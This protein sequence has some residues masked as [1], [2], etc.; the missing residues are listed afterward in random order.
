MISPYYS[1]PVEDYESSTEIHEDC[2]VHLLPQNDIDKWI[3]Y[4]DPLWFAKEPQS[5]LKERFSKLARQWGDETGHLSSPNQKMLHP[6]Y[7]AI[8]GM[9]QEHRDE[10]IDLLLQDLK[11]N[12]R[13][14]FWALSFLAQTNP[15]TPADAGRMDRMIDAW[16]RWGKTRKHA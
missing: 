9:G 7:Q 3:V 14:W 4:I 1:L 8:L 15:I 5:T 12:R 13:P 16:V 11:D 2:P 6:S 10:V